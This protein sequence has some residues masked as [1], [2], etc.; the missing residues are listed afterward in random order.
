MIEPKVV[1][2][3]QV[4]KFKGHYTGTPVIPGMWTGTLKIVSP[5]TEPLAKALATTGAQPPAAPSAAISAPPT[6]PSPQ[7]GMLNRSMTAVGA[8]GQ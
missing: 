1:Q 4:S 8:G 5:D 6:G 3:P 7:G 2:F